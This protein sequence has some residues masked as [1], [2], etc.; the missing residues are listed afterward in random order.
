M[1]KAT[2][3][4]IGTN[5]DIYIQ[6]TDNIYRDKLFKII[7]KPNWFQR[8]ILKLTWEDLLRLYLIEAAIEADKMNKIDEK[9]DQEIAE[10]KTA[11]KN[12]EQ[13]LNIEG[14]KR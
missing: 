6:N 4:R 7:T 13:E 14:I 3:K 1:W 9:R 12:I 2:Y 11:L 5:V 8:K 10:L